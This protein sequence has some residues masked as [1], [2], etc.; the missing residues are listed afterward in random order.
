M[1]VRHHTHEDGRKE[2]KRQWQVLVR[3]QRNW[4]PRILLGGIYTGAIL[5]KILWFL[6][7]N[8]NMELP[9][10]PEIPLQSI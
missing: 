2:K 5:R 7:N 9:Y 4:S 8:F 10:N 6:L 1:E 3:M